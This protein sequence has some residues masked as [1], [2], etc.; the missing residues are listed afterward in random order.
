M[1]T[2]E[3]FTLP[4]LFKQRFRRLHVTAWGQRGAPV[5]ICVHGLSRV[6]RDFDALAAAL[7]DRFYVL[8]PDLPGRGGSDWLDEGSDYTPFSYIEPLSHLISYA[9]APVFWVGTSLGGICGMLLASIPGTPI[10]RMVLNDIGPF[11]PA[12]ALARIRDYIG[13]RDQ[14]TDLADMAAY[15]RSVYGSFGDLDDAQWLHLARHSARARPGGGLTWHYDP[16]MIEPIRAAEP[17]DTQLWPFWR[18]IT[19]PM[20]TLRG[21]SSDLLLAETLQQMAEKSA[22]HT[23]PGCGHAPALMDAP[24]IDVIARFLT[25]A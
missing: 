25:A 9:A 23:V 19:A 20:L 5:V 21:A 16:K 2:P 14:F 6:G 13:A 24:S 12:A 22:I 8:C 3:S 4:Y 18:A 10:A 1:M 11:V 15:M 7:C 17:A